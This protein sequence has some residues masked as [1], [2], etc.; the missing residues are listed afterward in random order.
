MTFDGNAALQ[1]ALQEHG[2]ERVITLRERVRN[3]LESMNWDADGSVHLIVRLV[4]D[5]EAMLSEIVAFYISS[6]ARE[7]RHAER[8]QMRIA[9][10]NPTPIDKT[11]RGHRVMALARGN[12]LML[13]D[14][15]LPDGTRMRDATKPQLR[16]AAELQYKQGTTMVNDS[17]WYAR[18]ADNLKDDKTKVGSVLK[19]D[20]LRKLK[21]EASRAKR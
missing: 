21:E 12:A 2:S 14:W 4:R 18:V 1:E 15:R 9:A 11:Q 6:M 8:G 10:S 20:M 3:V 13:L 5:D 16:K 7:A 19:E 17:K